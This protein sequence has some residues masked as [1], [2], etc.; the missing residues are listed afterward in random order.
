MVE[1]AAEWNSAGLTNDVAL[2]QYWDLGLGG[3]GP[4]QY[5][6]GNNFPVDFTYYM[7]ITADKVAWTWADIGNLQP[8]LRYDQTAGPD[9]AT[10]NLD[11]LWIRVTT[12]GGVNYELTIEFTTSAIPVGT[13]Y[14]LELNYQT[15]GEVF[16]VFVWDG[17]TWNDR[18]DLN[19][20]LMTTW[21]YLLL[22]AEVIAGEVR[23]QYRGQNEVGDPIGDDLNIEYHRVN[24]QAPGGSYRYDIQFDTTGIPFAETY[25]LEIYYRVSAEPCQV[26][27]WNL[28][29]GG[30]WEQI[31]TLN[32]VA[33]VAYSYAV[34]PDQISATGDV[35]VRYIDDTPVGDVVEDTIDIEYHRVN[36][37]TVGGTPSQIVLG[38]DFAAQPSSVI[39]AMNPFDPAGPV[40]TNVLAV[41]NPTNGVNI[42]TL[43]A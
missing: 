17:G 41:P 20:M 40:T 26:W 36:A 18:G 32:S 43:T 24:A 5:T 12:A 28:T 4:T 9:G 30:F 13:T 34:P 35:L 21:N 38:Y 2:L 27:I 10:I 33:W 7:D 25:T 11:A 39:M 3:F 23:V 14:T 29:L 16:D 1:V 42:V 8:E 37:F 19:S 15:S 31:T 6:D 22:P